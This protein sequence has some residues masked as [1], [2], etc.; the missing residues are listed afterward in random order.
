M[1][2]AKGVLMKKILIV[3]DNKLNLVAAKNVLNDI[4][5]VTAVT[6]GEQVFSFLEKQT[7]DLILLDINMP[8]MDGFEVFEELKK[9][10]TG[11]DIPVIF[12]TAD[13]DAATESRCFNS[14]AIDFI[15]KPFVPEVMRSRISRVLEL[16][17]LRKSLADRLEKKT[18]EVTDIKSKSLK[19]ALTGL[20]NRNYTEEA[21]NKLFAEGAEGALMM[22][23]MD[24]FK[25][26]NDNYGHIAGDKTL[27]MFAETL[28]EYCD[29]EKDILCRIGGDEFLVFI[30]DCD[31]EGVAAFRRAFDAWLAERNKGA[32]FTVGSSVGARVARLDEHT[33]MEPIIH[34]SDEAMYTEKKRRHA[35]LKRHAST[36]K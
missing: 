20:W 21:V 29:T 23:D 2:A 13:N 34:A 14:G 28:E 25:A 26:I 17:D 32:R 9:H 7:C 11:K 35:E 10:E 18:Q 31:E 8:G 27:K 19:D 22:I 12:L 5:T 36:L 6:K 1:I 33:E 15:A 30:P 16:E 24:N 4:Y 3:D